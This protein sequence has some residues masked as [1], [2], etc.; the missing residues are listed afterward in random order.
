MSCIFGR[1]GLCHWTTLRRNR[2]QKI[3]SSTIRKLNTWRGD[4]ILPSMYRQKNLQT[5]KTCRHFELVGGLIVSHLHKQSNWEVALGL[6][7]YSSSY[8]R[9][10][11]NAMPRRHS[12]PPFDKSDRLDAVPRMQRRPKGLFPNTFLTLPFVHC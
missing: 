6:R 11:S 2:A 1:F 8:N 5:S 4:I 12:R 3:S 10:G 9:R 7:A